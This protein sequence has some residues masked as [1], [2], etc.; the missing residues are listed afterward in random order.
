MTPTI[1]MRDPYADEDGCEPEDEPVS[2][3]TPGGK[4]RLVGDQCSTCLGRPGNL[5]ML[6]PGRV[7][8]MVRGG[9]EG[10]GIICHQTLPGSEHYG[11]GA[12]ALCRW[13]FDTYGHLCNL[14]R[15][16]SRLGGFT[17]VYPTP[18]EETADGRSQG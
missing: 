7:K 14:M 2:V 13:W 17:E 1:P 12:P 8:Q 15:V 11:Y 6:R 4:P 5:M 3:L 10:G 16:W 9:I 18:A